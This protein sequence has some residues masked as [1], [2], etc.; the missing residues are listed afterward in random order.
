VGGPR[1]GA[2]AGRSADCGGAGMEG[3]GRAGRED[4]AEGI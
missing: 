4:K 3:G 2:E 1:I